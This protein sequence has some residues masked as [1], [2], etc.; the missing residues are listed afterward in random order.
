MVLTYFFD[1]YAFY[2]IMA[3]NPNYQKY[4]INTSII[5]TRLNLMEFYYGLLVKYSQ[6]VAE[7]CYNMFVKYT[8]ELTDDIIK[9]AMQFRFLNKN[10][11]LSYVD[12]IGYITAIQHNVKFLTGDPAFK[13]L[14]NVEFVE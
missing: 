9:K 12:C 6:K 13:D 3:A 2:E 5:L 7:R 10:K 1:T 11:N 4:T 8:I 14:E